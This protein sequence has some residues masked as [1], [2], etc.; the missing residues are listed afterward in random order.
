MSC[1]LLVLLLVFLRPW[2][3]VCDSSRYWI[4]FGCVVSY[5]LFFF[6]FFFSSRR[7]HT[8]CLSDWSSD[9]CS[10]DLYR[11]E[12]VLGRGG[13]GVVYLAH[14]IVL[15]RMVALKLLAPE[16]VEND[17][18]RERFLSES[19]LA[20]S[21]DHPNIVPIFDAGEVEGRLYIA[22][23]YVEGSDLRQL[24][25]EEG[26]LDPA[27]AIALLAP[28][29]DALDTAH[30]KGLVHRDVKPSN[31]LIDQAGRPYLAD[32][33]LSKRA[34]EQGL[35][36]SSDFGGSVD[37]V[38]PEE[39]ERSPVDGR[40]DVYA[41]ACVL[42]ECVIGRPPYRRG[43]PLAT[44][45]AHLNDPPPR[46][47]GPIDP[48]LPSALAKNPSERYETCAC[49]VAAARDALG[50]PEVVVVRDRRPLLLA[51]VAIAVLLAAALA[52]FF[53][54]RGAGGPTKPSTKPTL[55][56]TVDSLQRIDPRTNRLAATIG[57]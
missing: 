57:V 4:C 18:F 21:L 56:P 46:T 52:A 28:I 42:H 23:R 14:Q 1:N 38:S 41:L 22:M 35:V 25:N 47:G 49:L 6:F 53:S 34:S 9:V 2:L 11:I 17:R 51:A 20:A 26:A 10:S 5:I 19:R 13:M 24:L 50:V 15:D 44:L 31:V 45:F 43:S 36:E 3:L 7:R 39:I 54:T 30:A 29:A 48:V 37:Y 16:L 40:A 33:G 27:Q 32:F 12:R 55:T 8:R